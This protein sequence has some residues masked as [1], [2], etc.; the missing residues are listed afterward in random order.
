MLFNLTLISCLFQ[1]KENIFLL[2]LSACQ[3]LRCSAFTTKIFL[4]PCIRF[5]TPNRANLFNHTCWL[6]ICFFLWC[7]YASEDDFSSFFPIEVNLSTCSFFTLYILPRFFSWTRKKYILMGRHI[8][9]FIRLSLIS[10]TFFIV[11]FWVKI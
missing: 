1:F 2:L 9:Y 10:T 5:N 6:N 4:Q 3:S 11:K 8:A 7:I